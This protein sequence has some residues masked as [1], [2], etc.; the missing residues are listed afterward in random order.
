MASSSC[1]HWDVE[2]S[3]KK[4]RKQDAD[5]LLDALPASP[6]FGTGTSLPRASP[7]FEPNS[8]EAHPVDSPLRSPLGESP[9]GAGSPDAASPPLHPDPD[10]LGGGGGG[11][12]ADAAKAFT[13]LRVR[14]A[15]DAVPPLPSTS[16]DA[17][18]PHSPKKRKAAGSL[19]EESSFA[20]GGDDRAAAG[21]DAVESQPRGPLGQLL[22][23][24]GR[25][26]LNRDLLEA[27]KR[28]E[29]QTGLATRDTR[30]EAAREAFAAAVAA[31]GELLQDHLALLEA[32]EADRGEGGE[33]P[34]ASAL[35]QAYAMHTVTVFAAEG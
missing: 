34:S 30:R 16:Q 29:S 28:T 15:P 20:T 27:I 23:Q 5:D 19:R 4:P 14:V 13:E 3:S 22:A 7:F 26:E 1:G 6:I 21:G 31:A 8:L 35:L 17:A 25:I 11:G 18:A 12:V 9:H 32:E 2:K 33:G 10:H 24:F